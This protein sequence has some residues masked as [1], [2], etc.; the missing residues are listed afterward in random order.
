[1]CD[2]S[3]SKGLEKWVCVKIGLWVKIGLINKTSVFASF[4]LLGLHYGSFGYGK[5]IC[6]HLVHEGA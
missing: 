4:Q 5:R 2:T 1:M 6:K 3:E